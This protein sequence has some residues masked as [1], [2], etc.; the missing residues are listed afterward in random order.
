MNVTKNKLIEAL[1][2]LGE[3]PKISLKKDELIEK[4]NQFYNKNIK[5]LAT[6][7]N[8]DIYNLIKRLAKE[9]ENGIDVN[10]KYEL[11][12]NF[13]ESILIIEESIID[14]NKIHIRFHEGM[15][16]KLAKFINNENE[17]IIKK[18]QI[19]VDMIINI[20]D[21]YGLIKDYELLDM[22]NKFL[23][24][25]I[26]MSYLIQL[27]NLQID[28]RNEIIIGDTKN[29]NEIYLMTTLISNPEEI[30]YERERRDLYYKEYTKQELNRNIFESLVERREVREVI[31]FLK[32][33]KVEFAK[34]ATITMIMYI[35]NIVQ[36]DV[37]DFMEL[38]K[39]DFKDIDEA[40][41]YLRLVMNLHNNIPHYSL[42]GYSPNELLEMQLENSSV[43]EERKKSKIGRNDPCPCGSGKKYKNCC[44]NKVIQVDFSSKE[45][46][47]CVKEENSMMFFALRNLLLDY[48]NQKYNINKKLRNFDDICD[49][50][51][52]E[53]IDIRDKLWENPNIIK[54]YLK[55]NPNKL[56]EELISIIK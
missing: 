46:K 1:N 37:N 55:E 44:L 38:I 5:Q 47:D 25:N 54:N 9:D 28:L 39:I 8:V 21:I 24:Y 35:M 51:S 52:E 32:K 45:Y 16:N 19:I 31:E 42:Y 3:F 56:N 30:I 10:L 7:I 49:A 11:E 13:L 36:I 6:V 40:K 18:N 23:N 17:K 20:V 53:L 27:I 34:E 43:K 26:N 4:L 50:E 41:E 15:K 48:T 22:L 29:G 33:K 14:N 12:V 2:Y